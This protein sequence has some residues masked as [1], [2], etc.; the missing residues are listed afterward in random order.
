MLV[1]LRRA[2]TGSDWHAAV[3]SESEAGDLY[4]GRRLPTF[5]LVAVNHLDDARG[6]FNVNICFSENLFAG[7]AIL[8]VGFQTADPTPRSRG[9]NRHRVD[10]GVVLRWVVCR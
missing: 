10:R 3:A 9:G 5:V 1:V 8:D 2:P 4:S 6:C 7:K